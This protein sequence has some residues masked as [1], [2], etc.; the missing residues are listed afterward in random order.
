[1]EYDLQLDEDSVQA[2]HIPTMLDMAES[3]R[4]NDGLSPTPRL[5]HTTG[6]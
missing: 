5:F 1:M 4:A 6:L 3:A 2:D